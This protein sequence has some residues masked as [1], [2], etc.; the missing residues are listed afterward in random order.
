MSTKSGRK[1]NTSAAAGKR[2]AAAREFAQTNRTIPERSSVRRGR[3]AQAGAKAAVAQ[4]RIGS[5]QATASLR[6]GR[7]SAENERKVRRAGRAGR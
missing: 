2:A 6:G 5:A 7:M 1:V 3:A 4:G